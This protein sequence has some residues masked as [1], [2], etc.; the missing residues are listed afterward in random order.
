MKTD[1]ETTAKTKRIRATP[2]RT[3][4]R[5][6]CPLCEKPVKLLTYAEAA[7]FFKTDREEIEN[8]AENCKL[9]RIHNNRGRVMICAESLFSLFGDR[10]TQFLTLKTLSAGNSKA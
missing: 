10:P 8:L 2:Y 3:A 6:L 4:D 7:D 5:A 1:T 9:H